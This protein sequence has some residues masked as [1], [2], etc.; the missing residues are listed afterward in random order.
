[1]AVHGL[2]CLCLPHTIWFHSEKRQRGLGPVQSPG[3]ATLRA[4][5]FPGW[6]SVHLQPSTPWGVSADFPAAEQARS[7]TVSSEGCVA[8][9][10][11]QA[12]L[13]HTAGKSLSV[14]RLQGLSAA[15]EDRGQPSTLA[16]RCRHSCSASPA[17][18][19]RW[20]GQPA[21]PGWRLEVVL[22]SCR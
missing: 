18:P 17:A 16:P 8:A 13:L 14:P 21:G 4:Q 22:V 3:T 10:A 7:D 5:N 11:I 19:A 2:R 12:C 9:M 15:H 20:R 6:P 1:M